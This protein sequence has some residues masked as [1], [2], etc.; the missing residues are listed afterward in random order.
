MPGHK[1]TEALRFYR[2]AV[3]RYDDAGT[4][5]K[6]GRTTGA[7]YLSGY[8]VECALKAVLLANR[9][10]S[11]QHKLLDLFSGKTAHDLEWLKQ[12]IQDSGIRIPADVVKY[13]ARVNTWT[14]DLRYVAGAQ[15]MRETETF[16]KATIEIIEW[17]ERS[18]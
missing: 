15:A 18:I 10:V 8:T 3:Q 9:P 4:L 17:V 14:T 2:V 12:K 1:R 7:M 16:L 11:Q 5:L 13:L 6:S